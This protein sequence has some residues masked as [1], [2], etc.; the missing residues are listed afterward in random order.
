MRINASVIVIIGCALRIAITYNLA[1]PTSPANLHRECV[2]L[3]ITLYTWAGALA[4]MLLAFVG[5]INE[6][7][8]E[9]ERVVWRFTPTK[10]NNTKKHTMYI[11]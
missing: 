5:C 9:Q 3:H 4:S 8:N 7:K 2:S 10:L 11:V 1:K 6:K